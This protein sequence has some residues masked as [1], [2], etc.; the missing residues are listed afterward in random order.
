MTHHLTRRVQQRIHASLL[1]IVA[2][3]AVQPVGAAG[4]AQRTPQPRPI[5]AALDLLRWPPHETPAVVVV[6]QRPPA[7]NARAQGWVVPNSDGS[8][9]PTIYV[10]GWS[11]LYGNAL[12]NPR[13]HDIIR[14]AGVLAHERAHLRHGPDEETAY[15]EQLTTLQYLR[16][17]DVEIANVRRALELVKRRQRARR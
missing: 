6:Y 4:S 7:V 11:E 16:A 15:S 5:Q 14:L 9:Q 12:A 8:A 3:A 10:A 13:E 17:H 2:C 1:A